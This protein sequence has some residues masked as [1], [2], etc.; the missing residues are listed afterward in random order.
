MIHDAVQGM[1]FLHSKGTI[2]ADLKSPNL[3]V[4]SSWTVKVTDF[5]LA[6]LPA[7][8]THMTQSIM[9]NPRYALCFSSKEDAICRACS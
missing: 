6:A 8:E 9:T 2:H 3:L 4:D 7:Q 1:L 5:G